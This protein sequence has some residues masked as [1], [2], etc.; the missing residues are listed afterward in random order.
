MW[1]KLP[2]RDLDMGQ[3]LQLEDEMNQVTMNLVKQAGWAYQSNVKLN[4][5]HISGATLYCRLTGH[6]GLQL[7]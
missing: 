3:F 1:F 7:H 6:C 4:N 5:E 2:Y